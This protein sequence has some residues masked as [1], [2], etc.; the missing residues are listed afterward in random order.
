MAYVTAHI[1]MQVHVALL[2]HPCFTLTSGVST[3]CLVNPHDTAVKRQAG[4]TELLFS[5]DQQC[6][7]VEYQGV[8]AYTANDARLQYLTR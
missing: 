2:T 8:P 5:Y 3:P 4:L 1:S 6:N 7:A